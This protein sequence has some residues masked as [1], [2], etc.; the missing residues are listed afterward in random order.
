M[1]AS[2]IWQPERTPEVVKPELEPRLVHAIVFC[3]LFQFRH[4]LALAREETINRVL[5]L[6]RLKNY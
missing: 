1:T 6:I 3:V 2:V 4:G 5:A